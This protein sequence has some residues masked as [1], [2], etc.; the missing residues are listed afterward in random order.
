[1]ARQRTLADKERDARA[2]ELYR[3]GLTY[4]QIAAQMGWRSPA[5]VGNA[6]TRALADD[7]QA[8]NEEVR[9]ILLGRLQDYRASAW[10]VLTARHYVTTQAGKLVEGPDGGYLI[11]DA[12]VLNAVDRL[13]KID[14]REAVLRDLYPPAKHRVEVITEDAVDAELAAL[15]RQIAL[16]DA[17][18]AA[19]TGTA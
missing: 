16:N 18:A 5:S 17:R 14:D 8:A 15:N 13:L 4:R 6:I 19:D 10:N 7:H 12:P 1:M 11:D 9:Q 2:V 3:R